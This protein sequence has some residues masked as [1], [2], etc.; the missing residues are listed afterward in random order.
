VFAA[1]PLTEN[2]L[3]ERIDR[4][5]ADDISA[6]QLHRRIEAYPDTFIRAAAMMSRVTTHP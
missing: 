4:L 6:L 1:V 2:F 3:G 5:M